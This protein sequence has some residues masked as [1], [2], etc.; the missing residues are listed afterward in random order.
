MSGFADIIRNAVAIANTLTG[1]LQCVV[2]HY[3]WISDNADSIPQYAAVV[4]RNALVTYKTEA[5][6]DATGG[7]NIQSA[8]V[9]FF[10]PI[11]NNGAANRQEP[12]D[13]RDKI[14]L[15]DGTWGPIVSV[16]GPIDPSTSHP[17]LYRVTLGDVKQRG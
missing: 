2:S 15:P 4:P 6:K 8:T 9:E 14:V 16:D 12:I 10:A 3:A 5:R 17:F 7:E 1:S 11:E 13:P